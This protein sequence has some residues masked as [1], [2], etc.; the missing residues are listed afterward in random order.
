M[1]AQCKDPIAAWNGAAGNDTW[2][3][4]FWRLIK[5]TLFSRDDAE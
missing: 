3:G 4:A 5:W 2:G 1:F